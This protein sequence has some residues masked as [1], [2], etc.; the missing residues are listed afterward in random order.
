VLDD[1]EICRCAFGSLSALVVSE[2]HVEYLVEAVLDHPMA[3]IIGPRA[4]ASKD[5]REV[6]LK[7]VVS[8]PGAFAL[9]LY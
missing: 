1:G 2:D 6:M 7:R 5:E 9:A 3:R 4:L 8:V